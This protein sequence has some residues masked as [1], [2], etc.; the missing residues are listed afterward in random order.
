MLTTCSRNHNAHVITLLLLQVGDCKH[1]PSEPVY[2]QQH[3]FEGVHECC[4]APAHKFNSAT[5]G[6]HRGCVTCDHVIDSSSSAAVAETVALLQLQR[7]A[8][9]Y[10]QWREAVLE[11]ARRACGTTATASNTDAQQRKSTPN[12]QNSASQDSGSGSGSAAAAALRSRDHSKRD[13]AK[14]ARSSKQP[15]RPR[16]RLAAAAAACLSDGDRSEASSTDGT[17]TAGADAHSTKHHSSSSSSSVAAH[18]QLPCG[19]AVMTAAVRALLPNAHPL[20]HTVPCA[21]QCSVDDVTRQLQLLAVAD[22]SDASSNSGAKWAADAARERDA[23]RMAA[24]CMQLLA[25]RTGAAAA[26]SATAAAVQS[27]AAQRA[28]MRRHSEGIAFQQLLIESTSSVCRAGFEVPPLQAA[29]EL[30]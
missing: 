22:S 26:A 24:L 5:A 9:T 30:Q 10:T 20:Q 16:E 1:H 4:S 14:S 8:I 13:G 21:S 17:T 12:S 11:E 25:K 7:K 28:P 27:D 15:R 29:F 19:A 2:E 6:A 18:T 23:D 3:S